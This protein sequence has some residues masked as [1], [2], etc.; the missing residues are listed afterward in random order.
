MHIDRAIESGATVLGKRERP[1]EDD[2]V[3]LSDWKAAALLKGMDNSL[4]AGLLRQLKPRIKRQIYRKRVYEQALRLHRKI[5]RHKRQ[6]MSNK[7]RS[8]V[9]LGATSGTLKAY[10]SVSSIEWE[11]RGEASALPPASE[12]EAVEH[13]W[14]SAHWTWR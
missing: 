2:K 11:I 5:V 14:T 6:E 9:A 13:I 4:R 1:P 7:I 12:V 8:A 10:K 3:K